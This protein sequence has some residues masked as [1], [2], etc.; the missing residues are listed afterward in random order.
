MKKLLATVLCWSLILSGQAFATTRN[1]AIPVPG[2]TDGSAVVGDGPIARSVA[3]EAARL[4]NEARPSPALQAQ[5]Q[6]SPPSSGNWMSRH[7][8]AFCTLVGTGVGLG[9]GIASGSAPC[10]DPGGSSCST[11]SV[12]YVLGPLFGAVIG[13]GVGLVV[14]AVK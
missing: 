10:D 1:E 3:R 14:K 8:V 2:P 6:A 7:P 12:A 4:A 9:V 5:P 13:M 11:Q